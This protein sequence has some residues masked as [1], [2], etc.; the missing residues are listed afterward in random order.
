MC[1]Q[2]NKKPVKRFTL[3][4]NEEVRARPYGKFF[5]CFLNPMVRMI[6]VPLTVPRLRRPPALP[7]R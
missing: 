3:R 5:V 1:W 2:I 4:T 7:S 6:I